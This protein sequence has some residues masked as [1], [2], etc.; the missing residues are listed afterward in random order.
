M[1]YCFTQYAV[2]LQLPHVSFISISLDLSRDQSEVSDSTLH[3]FGSGD[4]I[5]EGIGVSDVLTE[6]RLYTS[7]GSL[8][9]TTAW[10]NRGQAIMTSHS[11]L[12][13]PRVHASWSP[14]GSYL[15]WV[16]LQQGGWSWGQGQWSGCGLNT[17]QP[18][19]PDHPPW[20]SS[21]ATWRLS[22]VLYR[23]DCAGLSITAFLRTCP[24]A[25]AEAE[26]EEPTATL[27]ASEGRFYNHNPH[28]PGATEFITHPEL[29]HSS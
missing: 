15:S 18:W 25:E 19:Y 26:A 3:L 1:Q 8:R 14:E 11:T 10:S 27:R 12:Q 13:E 7:S 29:T 16:Q 6:S 21:L 2:Y 5:L 22:A 24:M 20:S 4:S 28:T 23:L 9:N 17:S